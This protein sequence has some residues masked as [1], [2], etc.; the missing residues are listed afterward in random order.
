[1]ATSQSALVDLEGDER[2]LVVPL[3]RE[4][5]EGYYRWHAKRSLR[6]VD[7]VRAF[8]VEGELIGLSMLTRLAPEVGYVFYLAVGLA[9]RRRGIGAEL[10]DDAVAGFLRDG[11]HVV[12]GAVQGENEASLALFRSRGFRVV[13]RKELG[14][15]EGGLGAW[16]IRSQM[17]LVAGELLLGRR[18]R[19]SP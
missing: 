15:R 16:G 3:L 4:A 9:H 6:E 5:F 12:Y 17:R 10:L 14:Y 18:I 19:T 2:Q 1:M 7:R 13:E 11:V 8:R